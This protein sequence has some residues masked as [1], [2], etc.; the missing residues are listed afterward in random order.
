MHRQLTASRF[1]CVLICTLATVA[2]Q[3]T[4]TKKENN[5]A[6][7][8]NHQTDPAYSEL[9]RQE[10]EETLKRLRKIRAAL[11]KSRGDR[12]TGPIR[13][14]WD[15]ILAG[16]QIEYENNLR[17]EKQATY[18]LRD[19]EYI[20]RV[21]R[22]AE[23]FIYFILEEIDRR[24]LPPELALLPVIESA[25]RPTAISRS[26]AVGLWQFILPTSQFLGMKKNWWYDARRDVITSTQNALDY[27]ETLY[28]KFDHDWLLALAAYNG[29]HGNISRAIERNRRM[30]KPT[31]FWNL[32]LKIE[33]RRYVPRFLAAAQIY[34]YPQDYG[35]EIYPVRNQPHFASINIDRQVDIEA[36]AKLASMEHADFKQLNA[37]FLRWATPPKGTHRLLVPLD[38]QAQFKQELNLLPGS[39]SLKWHKH[40]VQAGDTLSSIALQY[41]VPISSL[42]KTNHL[43]SSLIRSGEKLVI[44]LDNAKSREK[45][46]K[47]T[48]T[49]PLSKRNFYTVQPGDTLWGI[50]RK[51]HISV[52]QLLSINQLD[53]TT[54]IKPGQQLRIRIEQKKV[55][56]NTPS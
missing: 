17:I 48:Y 5:V 53:S 1:T 4:S 9:T 34:T 55:V 23:P 21:S 35:V 26:N 2:C 32:K 14:V 10:T 30:G 22:R 41:G 8:G 7:A 11:K 42:K 40:T 36:A 51:H 46:H 29:G 15:R 18:L 16:R 6:L 47:V 56:L 24:N 43:Q 39:K 3:S 13:H 28:K 45:T 54:P 12:Y 52:K 20:T 31:D 49:V 25:Y 37:G 19:K 27:L 50:A 44:P 38:R 33:T